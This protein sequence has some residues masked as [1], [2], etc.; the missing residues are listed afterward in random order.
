MINDNKKIID[1]IE[2]YLDDEVDDVE[3][4]ID[5]VLFKIEQIYYQL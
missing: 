5:R 2:Y 1:K 4:A 3:I